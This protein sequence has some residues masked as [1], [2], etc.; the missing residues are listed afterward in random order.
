M[1]PEYQAATWTK[2]HYI[3]AELFKTL[4]ETLLQLPHVLETALIKSFNFGFYN[5]YALT[6]LRAAVKYAGY[7]L[8]IH[9]EVMS[10]CCKN[11]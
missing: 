6:G 5:T 9:H 7:K 2:P 1:L 4:S 10:Y 8:S 3:T 11:N